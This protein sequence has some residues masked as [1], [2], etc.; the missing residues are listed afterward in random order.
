MVGLL[1]VIFWELPTYLRSSLLS[2][3][4]I[5]AFS[6]NL[7]S[8]DNNLVPI[9]PRLKLSLKQENVSKYFVQDF[10]K[11]EKFRGYNSCIPDFQQIS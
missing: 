3:S 5:C 8:G 10:V 9:H 11:M 6:C 4:T 7:L 1:L 2:Y